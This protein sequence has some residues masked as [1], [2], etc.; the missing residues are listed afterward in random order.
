[1]HKNHQVNIKNYLHLPI[2]NN[3]FYK[4]PFALYQPIFANKSKQITL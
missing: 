3:V 2:L 1:M 4:P